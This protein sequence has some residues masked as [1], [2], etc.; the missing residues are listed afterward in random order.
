MASVTADLLRATSSTTDVQQFVEHWHIFHS[1]PID[2][3]LKKKITWDGARIR[4]CEWKKLESDLRSCGYDPRIAEW[5]VDDISILVDFHVRRIGWKQGETM[6][7]IFF[8]NS[9]VCVIA[10][11][12]VWVVSKAFK[13]FFLFLRGI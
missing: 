11:F 2:S 4:S 6:G 5:L 8:V 12:I 13:Q 3:E 7:I 1:I 9:L 10:G